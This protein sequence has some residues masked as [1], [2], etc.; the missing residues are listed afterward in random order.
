MPDDVNQDIESIPN[1][2]DVLLGDISPSVLRSV[3][4]RWQAADR[5]GHQVSAFENYVGGASGDLS[6]AA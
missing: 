6:R 2:H 1:L 5:A 3:V 4:S